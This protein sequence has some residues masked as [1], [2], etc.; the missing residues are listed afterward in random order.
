MVGFAAFFCD[1]PV[2]R[3]PP[4]V[5][6]VSSNAV[7]PVAP[8]HGVALRNALMKTALSFTR[9]VVSPSP[10]NERRGNRSIC[11]GS[12]TTPSW[13]VCTARRSARKRGAHETGLFRVVFSE[14][15][16]ASLATATD[17]SSLPE[18]LRGKLQRLNMDEYLDVLGRNLSLLRNATGLC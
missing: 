1:L 11:P 12:G 16:T 18:V 3:M 15:E 13:G 4:G 7:H 5:K 14:D 17:L 9:T 10:T 2:K 6:R 8:V